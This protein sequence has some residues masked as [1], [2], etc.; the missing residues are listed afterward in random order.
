V[1]VTLRGR[2]EAIMEATAVLSESESAATAAITLAGLSPPGIAA[3]AE[4]GI[5]GDP[6]WSSLVSGGTGPGLVSSSSTGD[7]WQLLRLTV[8]VGIT[9]SW[10][11][12]SQSL[13][14]P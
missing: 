3:A 5:G 8:T 9:E 1:T 11:D 2:N 14:G 13:P 6:W 4:T 7:L 12:R 10:A